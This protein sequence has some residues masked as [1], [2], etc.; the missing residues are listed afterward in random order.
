MLRIVDVLLECFFL[1]LMRDPLAFDTVTPQENISTREKIE[2]TM[3]EIGVTMFKFTPPEKKTKTAKWS[4]H[5][6]MGP[7]KLKIIEKFPVSKFITS[8]RGKDIENL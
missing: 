2:I 6:L 3:Q 7:A 8:Q 5:A 4:W 1:E